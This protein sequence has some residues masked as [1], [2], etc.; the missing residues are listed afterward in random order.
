MESDGKLTIQRVLVFMW[1]LFVIFNM[2]LC[3]PHV[4]FY[5]MAIEMFWCLGIR[6]NLAPKPGLLIDAEH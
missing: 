5:M 3:L 1:M 2:S 6:I 4:H